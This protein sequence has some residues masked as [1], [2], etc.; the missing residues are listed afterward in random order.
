MKY[1]GVGWPD[2]TTDRPYIPQIKIK[3]FAQY[4][5]W[6]S[7][8]RQCQSIQKDY[9][10]L[11]SYHNTFRNA[12]KHSAMSMIFF[13]WK[14]FEIGRHILHLGRKAAVNPDI[15]RFYL[16]TSL[17]SWHFLS[18]YPSY[19]IITALTFLPTPIET[20]AFH[21]LTI[22]SSKQY[23]E[24]KLLVFNLYGNIYWPEQ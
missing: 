14:W 10:P 24:P 2:R 16:T 8:Y 1:I 11:I 19:R 9:D 3:L 5:S 23:I 6:Y 20:T 15:L 17:F 21:F 4:C 13:F 18:G 22:F 7:L 12:Y